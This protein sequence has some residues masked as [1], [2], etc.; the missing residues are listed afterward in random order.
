VVCAL[1][2]MTDESAGGFHANRAETAGQREKRIHVD[3]M[4][5]EQI[6]NSKTPVSIKRSRTPRDLPAILR[7]SNPS[8]FFTVQ[9]VRAPTPHNSQF[10]WG[11]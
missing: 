4:P 7:F 9:S 3:V 10:S 1:K 5:S 8:R 11:A 6:L 2:L